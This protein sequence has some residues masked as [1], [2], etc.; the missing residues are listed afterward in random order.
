MADRFQTTR[1]SLVL[2]AAQGADGSREALEWLCG[3]Y[4]YP[5]YAFVRRQGL[6]PEAARD[7]TQSFFLSLL[8]RDSL[9][10]LDPR[11][12]RFRAFLLASIKHFL[13]NERARADAVKRRAD[14]PG[15]HVPLDGAEARYLEDPAAGLN[16]EELFETRWALAVLDRALRRLGDE[17]E[18]AG[19]GMLFRRLSGQ[20]TGNEAAYDALARELETSEGALRVT[21]HR[22]RRR[23]G[24]LLREEVAQTVS[25]GDDVEGELRN[26][27]H[28]VGR[29]R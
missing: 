1:W 3:T 27:L 17:H 25:S 23:L 10:R 20:L 5:L 11:Q 24:S 21:V 9:R 14:D 6:D 22:M 15:F 18:A 2:A 4:W 29:G 19:K 26:L 7:L 13:A 8:D 28:A 12:G 16:P